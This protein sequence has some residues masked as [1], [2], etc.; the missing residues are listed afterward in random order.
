MKSAQEPSQA[1]QRVKVGMTGLAFV[2]LLIGLASAIFSS[3]SREPV[4]VTIADGVRPPLAANLT[5]PADNV[6]DPVKEPLAELGVAPS[7]ETE[8]LNTTTPAPNYPE[9]K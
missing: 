3:A 5:S 8:A 7:A 6:T 2:M 9:Q 1:I 4:P